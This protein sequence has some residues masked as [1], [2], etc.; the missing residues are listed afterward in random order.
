[1]NK[2]REPYCVNNFKPCIWCGEGFHPLENLLYFTKCC[3]RQYHWG[4]RIYNT[5]HQSSCCKRCPNC[6]TVICYVCKQ[7][8]PCCCQPL[9]E[10]R[11]RGTHEKFVRPI[12]G[13]LK[14]AWGLDSVR[15]TCCGSIYGMYYNDK[16]TQYDPIFLGNCEEEV[17]SRVNHVKSFLF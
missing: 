17:L 11:E 10:L 5:W 4:C 9:L 12:Q 14:E 7:S 1:M 15:V 16:T 6:R 13:L 3:S 8:R 2:L